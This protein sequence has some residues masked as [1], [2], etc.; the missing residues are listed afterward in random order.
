[1]NLVVGG[2]GLYGWSSLDWA[3]LFKGPYNFDD[4]TMF[5]GASVATGHTDVLVSNGG[6]LSLSVNSGTLVVTVE[7]DPVAPCRRAW[8]APSDSYWERLV[9]IDMAGLESLER[10]GVD[11]IKPQVV[12]SSSPMV[13]V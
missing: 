12:V 1:M 10:M 8:M 4:C 9:Q 5:T 7:C 2:N 11:I 3:A 13:T 6:Q